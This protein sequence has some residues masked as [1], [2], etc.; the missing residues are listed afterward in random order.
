MSTTSEQGRGGTA[1]GSE[2][3]AFLERLG[4]RVRASRGRRGLSR[5]ALAGYAAVSERYL[6]QLESGQG[7]ISIILLRQVARALDMPL[8]RLVCDDVEQAEH[9]RSPRLGGVRVFFC[10]RLLATFP[11]D[12]YWGS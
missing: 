7:N 12:R 5:K 6:A 1:R 4:Q 3:A 2:D 10:H 11:P 9:E 8:E